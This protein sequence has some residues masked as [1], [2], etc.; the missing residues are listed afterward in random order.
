MNDPFVLFTGDF[1]YPAGGWDDFSSRHATRDEAIEAAA[2]R[3][4]RGW[5]Q[6]IDVRTGEEWCRSYHD[7]FT[8]GRRK[9]GWDEWSHHDAD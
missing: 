3:G 8:D 9:A 5:Q 2:N 7:R 4:G 1:Y 6:I